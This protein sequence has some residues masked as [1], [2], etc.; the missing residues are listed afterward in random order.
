MRNVI[1]VTCNQYFSVEWSLSANK[2][3]TYNYGDYGETMRVVREDVFIF[4]NKN[5]WRKFR[6]AV[7]TLRKDGECVKLTSHKRVFTREFEGSIYVTFEGKWVKEGEEFTT[8]IN[9]SMDEMDVLVKHLWEIDQ[10][11]PCFKISECT[12]CHDSQQAV[13]M[14]DGKMRK[15][16]LDPKAF[17]TAQRKNVACVYCGKTMTIFSVCHCHKF[18][19]RKCSAENFCRFCGKIKYKEM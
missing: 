13:K 10:L 6:Q 16:L 14:V 3:L 15:T 4:L 2:K 5:I 18:D 12:L 17:K 11:I 9:L 19:C 1:S 7:P 8:W